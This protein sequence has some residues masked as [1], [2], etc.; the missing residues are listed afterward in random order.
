ME[1]FSRRYAN[2]PLP[3]GSPAPEKTGFGTK[4]LKLQNIR[5]ELIDCKAAGLVRLKE[6]EKTG[7]RLPHRRPLLAVRPHPVRP[8]VHR[9]GE[10]ADYPF[11]FCDLQPISY[12]K[13]LIFS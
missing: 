7:R 10:Q 11:L 6:Y 4:S 1:V 13:F 9:G 5:R 8:D 2:S 3:V 12:R